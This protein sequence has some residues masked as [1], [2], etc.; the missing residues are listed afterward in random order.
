MPVVHAFGKGIPRWLAIPPIQLS[1]I[2][3]LGILQSLPVAPSALLASLSRTGAVQSLGISVGSG[4]GQV[5]LLKR[6]DWLGRSGN[7][8]INL[9]D[10]GKWRDR[11][12][13]GHPDHAI[14]APPAGVGWPSNLPAIYRITF[15]NGSATGLDMLL[16]GVPDINWPACPVG[17]NQTVRFLMRNAVAG[18]LQGAAHHPIVGGDGAAAFD[19]ELKLGVGSVGQ[20]TT[21]EFVGRVTGGGTHAY[22]WSHVL[23]RVYRIWW[24][25]HH[26]STGP[27]IWRFEFQIW[28][29][30]AGDDITPVLANSAIICNSGGH[31]GNHDGL[32][33]NA[34]CPQTEANSFRN[35]QVYT[36][37]SQTAGGVLEIGGWALS[38]HNVDPGRY[39][40]GLDEQ[41]L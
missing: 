28:D 14:V 9:T 22:S 36:Q 13:V 41:P 21:N 6:S 32:S 20:T 30:T 23:G 26:I 24:R 3:G 38:G 2:Q 37:G 10:G 25:R 16:G 39:G 7:D 12:G 17:Q 29:L 4:S 11:G 34:D 40:Q 15:A 5:T 1:P 35:F 18:G 33:G 31:G 27:D 19:N 8:N